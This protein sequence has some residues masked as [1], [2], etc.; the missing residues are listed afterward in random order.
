M[1]LQRMNLFGKYFV[2]LGHSSRLTFTASSF[3]S[4]WDASGQ[5]PQRAITQGH[6][7]RFGA[8]DDMEG[9]NTSRSDF[10][11]L[12]E[13][14]DEH[15]NILTIQGFA[16]RYDFRLFSNFTFFLEDPERGDMIEQ[17]DNRMILGSRVSYS[18]VSEWG[19]VI[20]KSTFG[21]QF[22]SDRIDVALHHSPDRMRAEV[23]SDAHV[24]QQNY[25]AWVVEELV[26]SPRFRVQLGLRGDYFTFDVE[27][28]AGNALE[29]SPTGVPHA[30]GYAQQAM[31]N[32]KLNLVWSAVRDLEFYLNTGTGFHSND[33]RN[34][35]I[36][37]AMHDLEKIWAKEGLNPRQVDARLLALNFDPAQ[38]TT[39]T[40]PRAIG[41][42]L[43]M[44]ARL[45]NRVDLGVAAWYLFLEKEFV[46]VGDGGFTELS[47]PTERIGIDL[48]LRFRWKSWLW[49]DADLCVSRGRITGLP[50]GS[51]HIPLAP[52]V[53]SSGGITLKDFHGFDASLR[54]LYV[55]D[56]P[57]NE[58]NTVTA[59]GYFV[60]QAGLVYS[61]R[62]FSFS[63]TVE[64]LFNTAWNE[65][66]FDTE[67]RLAWETDPV[68]EIHFTPGNPRNIQ[69]GI[70]YRF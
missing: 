39:T 11:M 21:G 61:F 62:Q 22:R 55:D 35:V 49:A 10:T 9:G 6:I 67:S 36:G 69:L 14:K 24:S 13:Q 17:L 38:K 18:L 44:R 27:D 47:D 25:S 65:A 57:A 45:W 42:E 56:R 34:V 64:N 46:Y 4:A 70:S 20:A 59:L 52:R 58:D 8:I 53:T 30:S 26:F 37:E 2:N 60:T 16:T 33:A 50:E 31:L 43:G 63:A 28:R 3:G 15:N 7:T 48:E 40:L 32:P 19:R 41:S 68:S 51:N 12:F 29:A 23:L 66:Q 1:H 54:Y 5:V